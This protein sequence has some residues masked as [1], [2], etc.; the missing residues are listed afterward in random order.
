MEKFKTFSKTG[1]KTDDGE[2]LIP[3]KY[4]GIYSTW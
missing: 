2:I 3:P 4:D 1:L